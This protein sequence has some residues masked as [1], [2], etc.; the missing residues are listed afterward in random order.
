MKKIIGIL[1]ILCSCSDQ[2]KQVIEVYGDS[3]TG[4]TVAY[5]E[6]ILWSDVPSDTTEMKKQIMK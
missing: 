6:K 5:K 1:F 3:T 4:Y 2:N